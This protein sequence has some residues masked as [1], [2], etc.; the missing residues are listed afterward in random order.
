MDNSGIFEEIKKNRHDQIIRTRGKVEGGIVTKIIVET[1]L[2][3]K[4]L[5]VEATYNIE[6]AANKAENFRGKLKAAEI[7]KVLSGPCN[8]PEDLAMY[9]EEAAYNKFIVS[10][11][12]GDDSEASDPALKTKF[13]PIAV[14]CPRSDGN[15]E[16][17]HIKQN[18]DGYIGHI[19]LLMRKGRATKI[20]VRGA[21]PG[22]RYQVKDA[23]DVDNPADSKEEAYSKSMVTGMQ[24]ILDNGC[25]QPANWPRFNAM[26]A[27][28]RADL[29]G[30]PKTLETIDADMFEFKPR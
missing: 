27:Q 2:S 20:V 16:L 17:V 12:G 21:G 5:Q 18:A 11:H 26:M 14:R 13:Q 8:N 19:Q 29:S 25:K 28:R 7:S 24:V 10:D 22:E 1:A 3:G 23:L 6:N 30:A 15:G 4:G 9:R